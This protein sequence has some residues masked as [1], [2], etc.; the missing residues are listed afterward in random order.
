MRTE[1]VLKKVEL[2]AAIVLWVSVGV[3]CASSQV[4]TDANL[5]F[6]SPVPLPEF[7]F[8]VSPP[9]GT[10]ITASQFICVS[11]NQSKLWESGNEADE[12]SKHLIATSELAVDGHFISSNELT[13]QDSFNLIT[14]PTGSHSGSL[15]ICTSQTLAKGIHF[16]TVNTKT[17]SGKTITYS[18]AFKIA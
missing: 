16:A 6:S 13:F 15:S 4:T 8:N 3:A 9:P 7:L 11:L 17:L 14:R 18:W 2:F 5:L 12:L 10:S 1:Y